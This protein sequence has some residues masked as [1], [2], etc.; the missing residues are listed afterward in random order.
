[1]LEFL[2]PSTEFSNIFQ[3]GLFGQ[4]QL[5]NHLGKCVALFC[6]D[7]SLW[8]LHYYKLLST[9]FH[10]GKGLTS[11]NLIT[12]FLTH[13]L[14]LEFSQWE[15]LARDQR[16]GRVR[17]WDISP[18]VSSLLS[19]SK[20][21][22]SLIFFYCSFLHQS[23]CHRPQQTPHPLLYPSRLRVVL[24]SQCCLFLDDSTFLLG[25]LTLHTLVQRYKITFSSV[26]TIW[27]KVNSY[28]NPDWYKYWS[29]I[30]VG[31]HES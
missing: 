30:Y 21:N 9:F 17:R 22:N 11:L 26:R 23:S 25:S 14:L 10:S 4:W 3:E 8:P 29:Y 15:A 6:A 16:V 13:W 2:G 19:C 31:E 5:E 28:Q 18:S 7:Y 27:V 24:I 1:M 20:C 12:G